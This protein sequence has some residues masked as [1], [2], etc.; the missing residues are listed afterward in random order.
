M[1]FTLALLLLLE[2]LVLRSVDVFGATFVVWDCI[3]LAAHAYIDGRE[4]LTQSILL[5]GEDTSGLGE[6]AGGSGDKG[7]PGDE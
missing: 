4:G 3:V 1:P 6:R 2:L 7:P 5:A